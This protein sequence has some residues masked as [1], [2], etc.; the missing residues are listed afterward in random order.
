MWRIAVFATAAVLAADLPAPLVEMADVER[1]FAARA[2]QVGIRDSFLEF[3]ADAA[4]RFDAEPGP[5][6]PF[7]ER[8]KPQPPSVV[9]LVWE[10]RFGDVASSGELGYLTGPASRIVQGD[11][12]APVAQLAY[13]SIWKRQA[14][15][16]F[17]VVI[18]Q[19]IATPSAPAFAPGLTRADAADRYSGPPADAM[20]TLAAA[21]RANAPPLAADGRLYRDGML[22]LVGDAA[23]RRQREESARKTSPLHAEAA[24]S[25]DLGFTYGKYEFASGAEH[26]HYV[27]VWTR[28]KSGVWKVALEVTAQSR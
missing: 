8:L 2:G 5:A 14:N 28:T 22:P 17:R 16:A 6:K 7:L 25:G 15:G 1:A 12:S 10:P 3:F 19:G 21:D 24:R 26:G 18:D 11:P 23:R 13:F 4:V 9:E 27:R 20:R